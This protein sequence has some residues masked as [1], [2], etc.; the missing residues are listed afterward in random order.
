MNESNLPAPRDNKDLEHSDG[1][2]KVEVIAGTPLYLPPEAITSGEL[3][4]RSDLYAL[5]A[6][7]YFLLAGRNVFEGRTVVEVCSHH[8]HTPPLPPSER[9]GRPLPSQLEAVINAQR[10]GL[11]PPPS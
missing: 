7:G 6:V 9:L 3:D 8:L 11:I 4:G 2:S 1:L 5:G 10:A